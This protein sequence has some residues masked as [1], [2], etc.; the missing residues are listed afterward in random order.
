MTDV[1]PL[2]RYRFTVRQRQVLEG[3]GKGGSYKTVA[4]RLGISTE[5]V[6]VYA[7]QVAE[8]IGYKHLGPRGAIRQHWTEQEVA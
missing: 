2:L 5:T 8:K 1:D 7:K 3:I 4:L 6:R